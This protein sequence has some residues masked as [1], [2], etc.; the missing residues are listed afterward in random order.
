MWL[1]DE[2]DVFHFL[3]PVPS[4]IWDGEECTL[5]GWGGVCPHFSGMGRSVPSFLWDGEECTLVGWGGVYPH[6][7]GRSV[8]S[9]DREE[10]VL[11]G[12]GGVYPSCD[13]QYCSMSYTSLLWW[14]LDRGACGG[15]WIGCMWWAL[16]RGAC[17]GLWIG[18]HVVG[19]G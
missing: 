5:M 19:S 11:M 4:F 7:I 3:L 18:V 6:G 9:W 12:W 17:G 1:C 16:D 2:S 14:A 10:C 13:E 15:L 8:P